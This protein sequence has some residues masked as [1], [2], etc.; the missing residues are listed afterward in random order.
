M[1]ITQLTHLADAATS[2]TPITPSPFAI[3]PAT[4]DVVRS[5]DDLVQAL[6]MRG[7]SFMGEQHSPWHE[8]FDG[9]DF[10][11]THVLA[12]V[13]GEPAGA[14]RIRWFADWCKIERL[15][16]RSEFRGRKFPVLPSAPEGPAAISGIA[17]ALAS[18]AIEHIRRKGYR[19]LLGHAQE[20][21]L[22]F[23]QRHHYRAIGGHE[24]WI[25]Y[26]DHVYVP[27]IADLPPHPAAIRADADHMIVVRPE[28][29][30]DEPGPFDWS[31]SRPATCPQMDRPN[32]SGVGA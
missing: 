15:S 29:K 16:V 28:G 26:A 4:V 17:D 25:V 31:M 8:E 30:W 10:C 14:L 2:T 11:C 23:W 3:G 12:K 9:S 5:F 6:T 21:L 27:M 18:Y 13:S 20:R 24:T 32:F 7:L 22:P 1:S 19:T